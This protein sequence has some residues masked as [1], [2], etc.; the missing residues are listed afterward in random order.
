MKIAIVVEI[1]N[2]HSGARAPLEIAKYLAKRNHTVTVY[3]Y[4]YHQDQDALNDMSRNNVFIITCK[5]SSLPLI[6]KYITAFSL[7]RIL[8]KS[9]PQIIAFAGTL[10]FFL[11]SRLTRIPTV[12]MYHGIQ[13]NPYLERKNPDEKTTIKDRVLNQISNLY[14]YLIN[15]I[16]I[17]LSKEVIAISKFAAKE[18]ER[19]YHKKVLTV[20]YLGTT[21]LPTRNRLT[22]KKKTSIAILSVSRITPYKGFHLIIEAIKKVKTNK[23][24][25]LTIVGSQPKHKYVEYLKKIGGNSVVIVLDPSDKKLSKMYQQSDFYVNADRYLYFGL[26][27]L[28]AAQFSKPT[29]SFNFAAASEIIEHGKTGYVTKN[30]HDFSSYIKKLIEDDALRIRLGKNARER[31]DQF[32]W[33]KCAREWEEILSKNVIIYR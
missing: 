5:G 32:S 24:V 2:Y 29:V 19:L 12:L 6:G 16:I 25:I 30:I 31:S 10:P 27:I 28:E 22:R 23:K 4:N 17:Y 3:A 20:I 18:V 33:E 7:F 9:S 21:S 26:P 14:I 8:K 11:S 15:G 13:P 1:I